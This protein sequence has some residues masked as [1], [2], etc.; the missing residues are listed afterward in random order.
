MR[1]LSHG[2]ISKARLGGLPCRRVS[3]LILDGTQ[4]EADDGLQQAALQY[5]VHGGVSGV[6][7][8]TGSARQSDA[9]EGVGTVLKGMA[10]AGLASDVSL[11]FKVGPFQSRS[12]PEWQESFPIRDQH[13]YC[14]HPDYLQY[15]IFQVLCSA[16]P[17]IAVWCGVVWC[18]VEWSGVVW[19]GVVWCGAGWSGVVWCGAGWSGVGWGGVGWG[20]VGWGG[21][22]WGGAVRCGA[23]RCGAVWCSVL[24]W[25][26]VW[27][28]V[29]W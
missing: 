27:W 23:V 6:Q 4:F 13:Y 1:R 12:T 26:V 22:G 11:S 24:W 17:C 3:S 25:G 18:G 2:L 19:C 21:M 10:A 16:L 5:A 9:M 29:V 28:G 8:A 7:I 15:S 20:G 14:L